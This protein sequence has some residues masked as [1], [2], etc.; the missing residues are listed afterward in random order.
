MNTKYNKSQMLSNLNSM[1]ISFYLLPW[2]WWTSHFFFFCCFITGTWN[3]FYWCFLCYPNFLHVY[4]I[5]ILFSRR[6]FV[7]WPW[8][9]VLLFHYLFC[10][11]CTTYDIFIIEKHMVLKLF[12]AFKLLGIKIYFWKIYTISK[13]FSIILFFFL[14]CLTTSN[15]GVS[16]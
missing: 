15:N 3:D 6:F 11:I 5:K 8:T 4:L 12:D 14:R 1:E 7:H 10:W 2:N 13:T 9:F 16:D